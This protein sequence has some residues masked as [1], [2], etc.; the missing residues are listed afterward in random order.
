MNRRS[1]LQKSAPVSLGRTARNLGPDGAVGR[2]SPG[3]AASS[4]IGAAGDLTPYQ[5]R[6][7]KPWD[8]R[9]AAHLLR[10]IGFGPTWEEIT[11]AAALTPAAIVDAALAASTQA[12]PP[13][14][15]VNDP[16]MYPPD[17]STRS[18]Y[19]GYARQMQDWW[20]KRMVDANSTNALVEKMV[21]FWHNHFVSEF[22]KVDAPHYMYIQNQLFRTNVFGDFKE[23]TKKVTI[24]GAM[25]IYL[26]GNASNAGNPNENYAR[27]LLELFTIGTGVYSNGTPHYT[28]HDIIELARA[29]T[30]W[31]IVNG[32]STNAPRVA[33]FVPASFDGGDKTIMGATGNFGIQ[34]RTSM[35]VIDHIFSVDDPDQQRKRAAVFICTKLYQ[36]FVYDN[37]P[38]MDIVKG[39]A[40]TLEANNW[41]IGPVLRELLL[42]EH[43]M[44]DQVIGAKIKSP[45]EFA[46]GAIR[47]MKLGFPLTKDENPNVGSPG[48][49]APTTVMAYLSQWLLY[50][51]NVKGWPGGRSWLSSATVPL[52]IRY[53]QLWADPIGGQSL[54]AYGFKPVD[55]VK[56]LPDATTDVNK[57]LDHLLELMLPLA[58]TSD[59]R[60]PLLDELLGGGQPYEWDPDA[61]NAAPRIRACIVAIISLGEYQLM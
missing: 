21:L 3:S 54:P 17:N 42:S 18:Q 15:W 13:A 25:L 29:L 36:Y 19:Y 52:R 43:F 23:L 10:R 4:S 33:T 7:E 60:K 41:Q 61:P 31:R 22:P 1:F 27:E 20:I 39:M 12:P 24:D 47:Q 32:Y 46:V 5:P 51:P 55:F 34:G 9:R 48:M 53:A 35:D 8:V 49:H 38:D 2:R 40:S 16:I 45:A 30:G 6:S 44:D 56:S 26:D 50:P 59:A 57:M 28:E 37:V 58:I 11:A 14:A